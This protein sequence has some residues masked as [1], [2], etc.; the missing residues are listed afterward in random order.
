[1][2]TLEKTTISKMLGWVAPGNVTG[3]YYIPMWDVSQ[4]PLICL[5]ST[6]WD[7]LLIGRVQIPTSSTGGD[8]QKWLKKVISQEHDLLLLFH[9]QQSTRGYIRLKDLTAFET[10]LGMISN[11]A[12]V[13]HCFETTRRA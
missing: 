5:R 7:P 8:F 9:E 12:D 1:M 2:S 11:I 13:L 4:S 6:S 10:A 3:T